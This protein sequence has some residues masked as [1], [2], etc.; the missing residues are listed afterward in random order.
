MVR[1][2]PFL[3]VNVPTILLCA[4]FG[5][6][7][8]VL[9]CL[10]MEV[11]RRRRLA[12]R[13]SL[14]WSE[15]RARFCPDLEDQGIVGPMVLEIIASSIGID[16]GKLRPSDRFGVELRTYGLLIDDSFDDVFEQLRRVALRRWS[17]TWRS[18]ERIQCVGD[19][20][21]SYARSIGASDGSR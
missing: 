4:I 11:H 21:R 15:W 20:V 16:P 1:G 18:N 7:G 5:G 6:A 10:V 12:G 17:V 19:V 8:Y 13:E 9:W 14:G 2:S 3:D